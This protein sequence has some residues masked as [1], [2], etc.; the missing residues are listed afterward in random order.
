MA[1]TRRAS[2]KLPTLPPSATGRASSATSKLSQEGR[3]GHDAAHQVHDIMAFEFPRRYCFH[4]HGPGRSRIDP[5]QDGN[6]P[7]PDSNE[8][9]LVL[10]VPAWEELR[11]AYQSWDVA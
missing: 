7:M 8:P 4:D 10:A 11:Q 1:A 5:R 9:L 3:P 6:G 2:P